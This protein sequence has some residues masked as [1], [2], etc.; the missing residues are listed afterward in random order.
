M[1]IQS[2]V[3]DK[4]KET[5]PFVSVIMPA[6]NSEKFIS[7]AVDSI[8]KQGYEPLEIIVIDD[9]STDGTASCIKSLGDDIRYVYQVNSGPAAARNRGITMSRGDVIA[10]LDADDYWPANKLTIQ[11][12]HMN[13][14]PN[15]E[16]VLGRIRFTGF[17]TEAERRLRFEGR[18]NTMINVNLGSGVFR[19]TVFDKVG[20]FDEALR[21]YEDHDWFLRAREKGVSMI[22]VK[23]VTLYY[24]QSENGLSRRKTENDPSMMWVLKK[25]LDRRRQG[26]KGHIELSCDFF[27]FDEDNTLR[28]NTRP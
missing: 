19:K 5:A 10:F 22:I 4:I 11:L 8:R 6:Y 15:I 27:D 24:R 9:G 20:L 23:D 17:L 26:G 21:H 1:G 7:E 2:M 18:D 16:V 12:A 3:K 14:N 28:K 25:S 13:I